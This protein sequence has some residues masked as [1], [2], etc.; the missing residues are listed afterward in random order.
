MARGE[1]PDCSKH[2][3]ASYVVEGP[4]AINLGHGCLR[5]CVSRRAEE[6]HCRID[7][8]FGQPE[9]EGGR[10]FDKLGFELLCKGSA[11]EA[12]ETIANGQ[13]AYAGRSAVSL[14]EPW[15]SLFQRRHLA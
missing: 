14:R 10:C 4:D 2:S 11:D 8:A 5:V 7:P 6:M 13:T 15:R 3:C 12:S 9:L 1:R